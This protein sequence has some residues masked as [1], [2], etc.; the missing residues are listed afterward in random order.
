MSFSQTKLTKAEWVAMEI[1]LEPAERRILEFLYA[2]YHTRDN[3]QDDSPTLARALKTTVLTEELEAYL[4][5]HL[6]VPLV[7]EQQQGEQEQEQEQKQKQRPTITITKS[8]ARRPTRLAA[9]FLSTFRV[10]S[11]KKKIKEAD[12]IRV[13]K[14]IQSPAQCASLLEYRFL[15]LLQDPDNEPMC[16]GIMEHLVARGL[17]L[18]SIQAWFV[19]VL[20]EQEQKEQGQGQGQ[21]QENKVL[22]RIQHIVRIDAWLAPYR[23]LALYA[24]QQQLFAAFQQPRNQRNQRRSKL[25]LY[26]A[27]TGSGKTISPLGLLHEYAVIFVC[28]TRHVGL[29]LAKA[30]LTIDRKVAVAFGCKTA[31]DIRLH[32]FAAATYTTNVRTGGIGKIDHSD[33][34][35]VELMI[36]DAVS[37]LVAMEYMLAFQPR[38]RLVMYWDEPTIAMDVDTHPLHDVL[39]RMWAKNRVPNVVLSSATLPPLQ[40]L[41]AVMEG[42][43][44]RHQEEGEGQG[45]E[46]E[47]EED[48]E[49][50]KDKK[51][52][53]TSIVTIQATTH[54]PVSSVKLVD[55]QGLVIMPH[56]LF[57]HDARQRCEAAHELLR[58]PALWRYL[59]FDSVVAFVLQ[60]FSSSSSSLTVP[61]VLTV[62]SVKQ[63]YL[64]LLL[65]LPEQMFGPG[66][67]AFV[68]TK[69]NKDLG[70]P[71]QK[72]YSVQEPPSRSLPLTKA[73]SVDSFAPT[74]TTIPSTN[75]LCI[76]SKDA[77]TVTD[78]PALFLAE[79][80]HK[81]GLFYLQQA[82]IPS[83]VLASLRHKLEQMRACQQQVDALEA[84]MAPKDDKKTNNSN[85]QCK[86]KEDKKHN[87]VPVAGSEEA[88]LLEELEACRAKLVS[89]TLPAKYVPNTA[90]HLARWM[91]SFDN[92]SSLFVPQI[93]Q[94]DVEEVLAL[95]DVADEHKILLLMGVGL[96]LQN[97]HGN[98]NE[99]KEN[100]QNNE[101]LEIMKRLAT[102]RRLFLV[103]ASS[104]YIYGTNYAFHHGFLGKDLQGMTKEKIVQALGRYGRQGNEATVRLRDDVFA[105]RLFLPTT[106][107]NKEAIV[108]TRL[109]C[110]DD[111]SDDDDSRD[112]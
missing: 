86:D 26:T 13:H 30:A 64:Q 66:T 48:E 103:V 87:R 33:G 11:N 28:V 2:S 20:K 84:S 105:R 79:D 104:D 32:H 45:Q 31:S 111:E 38:H 17:V 14:W 40:E 98:N 36:C 57:G 71:L 58:R 69:G 99:S 88:R 15:A 1:P 54:V 35:R 3:V 50:K 10:F 73:I 16:I 109:F 27:P 75:G 59:D 90:A 68:C 65:E 21:G 37:Y 67:E 19:A 95:T 94:S 41:H 83:T 52:E 112:K 24:H 39:H 55:T 92:R 78:G 85:N 110:Y 12:R 60:H 82:E 74:R 89:V 42:F 9:S 81:I 18:P 80:P 29:A 100:S 77:W 93:D 107:A 63:Y 108:M 23:P 51:E 72:S 62:A 97:E 61:E 34:R 56:T 25:V 96:F 46:E 106:E 8:V 70:K 102:S 76:T 5:Q 47:E 22:T 44:C 7:Q 101:Y 49:D 43:V 91:P 4:V 6:L 53:K